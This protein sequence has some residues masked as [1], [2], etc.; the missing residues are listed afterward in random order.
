MGIGPFSSSYSPPDV[1]VSTS[2][3]PIVGQL[4]AG[5]RVP[6]FIGTGS[7]T[8]S[9]TDFEL[10]RGSSSV[11]DTPI[12][13]E[14]ATGQFVISG[15]NNNPVLGA[16]NGTVTSFRVHNYP[17]VDGRGK[18]LVTYDV[19]KVS[20]TV[21]GSQAVVS[22]VDGQNGIISLLI[23]P[24][25]TDVVLVNYFFHRMDTRITD[26]VSAQISS[27]QA[28]LVA[29]HVETYPV[30]SGTN[31]ILSVAVND[32][33]FHNITLTAG[34]TRAAS[35]IANDINAA[36]VS[37]LS[38]SVHIDNQGLNHVQMVASG[39]VLV[40]TGTA[41]GILGFNAGDST[42][43]NKS[44]RVFN[45]PIVDG[46][47]G[48]ITTTD[49]TRV[50]V[51]VNGSQV[52]A[53]SVDGKNQTVILTAAPP[54]G[55]TVTIQYYFN[56]WQDTF[57]YLPN[58]NVVSVGNVG[59]SPN[60]RDF[61]NGPDFLIINDGDQSKIQWGTAFHVASGNQTGSVSFDSK[62]ITGMLIDNRIFGTPCT[63]FTD[64]VTSQVSTT[65]FTM[66]LSPTT[67]NG[68]DTPLGS[69]LYQTVTNGRIDLPTNRPDLVVV[70]VGK[71]F[72]DAMARPAA[73]IIDV[74]SATNTF[75]LGSSVP[76]D[77]QVYATFWYN[78]I[79]DDV[80]TLS[81]VSPGSS[82][83]GQY[84]IGSQVDGTNLFNTNFGAKS[85]LSQTVQW[86]SGSQT[87]PDAFHTGDGV[88]VAETVT[89]T[90]DNTIDPAQGASFSNGLREPYDLYTYTRMFGG[91]VIDGNAAISV[92]LSSAFKATLVGNPV[93]T[94]LAPL[95]TDYVV[96]S[97]DG[98]LIAPIL[99]SGLTTMSAVVGAI[100]SAIDADTQVHTD[101]T[102][103]FLSTAP[104]ALAS[105]LSIGS[106]NVLVLKS[107]SAP[108]TTNGLISN[109]TVLSPTTG[110]QTNGSGAIGLVSNMTAQGSYN[111]IN[112][113]GQLAS[114][115]AG[116]YL[117]Q[118]GV[119][120]SV[121]LTVDGSDFSAV[122][123]AGSAITTLEA[124]VAI[125][126]AYLSVASA[127][128]I[129][130]YTSDLISLANA[131]KT[132]F[133]AHLA[134]TV[135][136]LVAD[137]VNPIVAATA[138]DL[139]SSLTMINEMLT[140]Y[141]SHIASSTYHQLVDSVNTE[142]LVAAVDLKT[143]ITLAFSLK[144]KF[145]LHLS[146]VGVHGYNDTVNVES[147]PTAT[148]LTTSEVL[149]NSL[150]TNFNAH[151]IQAGV[152]LTN[153][154]TNTVSAAT[155]V[156]LG[157]TVTLAN[158]IKA[159]FN[160]HVVST[161]Y[162]NVADVTVSVAN[163]TDQGTAN[164]LLNALKTAFN[165][166]RTNSIGGYHVHGTNDTTNNVAANISQLVA[167]VGQGQYVGHLLLNS[168][169]NTPQSSIVFKSTSTSGSVLGFTAGAS[170]TRVQPTAAK[171]ATA[172]NAATAFSALAIAV[173]ILA[174]GLGNYLEINS[175]TVGSTSTVAFA[176]RSNT[177]FISDTGLGIVPGISG[178][179][180]E[181]AQ[182]G[183]HVTSSAGVSGSHG[184]GIPG[185]TY[186][187]ATTG[188]RFTILPASAGDYT[189]GGSFTLLIGQTFTADASIPVRAVG[190]IEVNVY[191]TL[192]TNPGTTALLS[193]YPHK[194]AQPAVG[195][196]YYI[197][198]QFQKTDLNTALYQDLK[199]IQAAFGLATPANP[200][201]LA[202]RL[203]QLNGSVI[204]GLKQVLRVPGSQQASNADFALAID[205]QKAP[206]T[207]NIKPDVI[208]LLST[209]PS[210][211][212]YLSQHC[213][214]MSSP[215]QAGERTGYFG[216]A[217]GTTPL[218][219]QAIA[220]GLSSELM[221][222]V[223]PDSFVVNITDNSGITTQQ[224]VDGSYAAAAVAGSSCNPTIDVATPF[225]RRIIAGFT[226]IGRIL[227]PTDADQT[228]VAGV[229]ILEQSQVGIRI[230]HGLT[231]R[232]DD[233]ITRTPS[234]QLTIQ[235]V[236]Q[237]LRRVLDPFIGAKFS[238]AIIKGAE[239]A[240]TGAFQQLMDKQ[241]VSKVAGISAT[242]DPNDP[243]VLRATA[244]FVPIFPL[245]Y[246]VCS[247]SVRIS[248]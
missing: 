201:S 81:V 19:S 225:T 203:A 189:S 177:A 216:T 117:I 104:N 56:T 247:L 29:P 38:A 196:V 61:L 248:L 173:S 181:A 122:L 240:M 137:A 84:T 7:E 244:V 125:N 147:S 143:G 47:N 200:L 45:G 210:L 15:T 146:Q 98:V 30:V 179:I 76:A 151:L 57:D 92:D 172:L 154:V 59:I 170:S 8:L 227:S 69:S 183:F 160:L 211:A 115:Q 226:Q 11:A 70:H 188:L 101:G 215:R 68:R 230:R 194:G 134:S 164:T 83:V 166:H 135:F 187:D 169:V 208:S 46:S 167:A 191:N 96:L 239:K 168:R 132:G 138:T 17:I 141:N 192:N 228:A 52:L 229:T 31:D 185:Q 72:R 1:Y 3:A 49:P 23:P 60:R 53:K 25:L 178:A 27:G 220:Q 93:G 28:V 26:D 156:D 127:A 18:G 4:L 64:P 116:P 120:D 246:I 153:D 41:N 102:A 238:G 237:T 222:V 95:S 33:S 144:E 35:D 48:G 62:Q 36:S 105:F 236:Q 150:K 77:Y 206:I 65:K 140:K 88:P 78:R 87:I 43:R 142:L 193:T 89:V 114:S 162:H 55:A 67:G 97:V 75:V 82:G 121:Q 119:N 232:V 2:S 5:L 79:A 9:Q 217:V 213:I 21:N 242:V 113:P 100:N 139:A 197:S 24:Q 71:N 20:A 108:S 90:F 50:T 129:A 148:D 204:V 202:A 212:A 133:N 86:P 34:A 214:F 245:E 174:P 110:G 224:L 199:S 112:Q 40:G 16:A 145:N 37:G 155:A 91:V 175:R 73:N 6:V 233:V 241:I 223:Y 124:A 99:L 106:N 221:T 243:T 136:H 190:G 149:A 58:S 130:T 207:G 165:L 10:V 39:N 152:H 158:Q 111:A 159:K 13:S 94:T 157:T 180:G 14:D 198:Y 22:Q 161:I 103:T 131:L 195:D 66:P 63:R 231:T 176:T 107:R 209:D 128:D 109:V 85:G 126:D 171:I 42:S 219:C 163:A 235:Y 123:P 182:S 12:F 44:F 218:G 51:L 205:E 184:T 80:F 74:D 118:S 54:D 234:V 32:G 186:T